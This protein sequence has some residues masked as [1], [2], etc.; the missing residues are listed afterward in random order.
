MMASTVDPVD[1]T[2]SSKIGQKIPTSR[3][4]VQE[5]DLKRLLFFESIQ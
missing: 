5:M 4:V 3:R 2:N 1:V